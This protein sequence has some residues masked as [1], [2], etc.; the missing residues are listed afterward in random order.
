MAANGRFLIRAGNG[1]LP[2]RSDITSGLFKERCLSEGPGPH[3]D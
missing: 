1:I 3:T 2:M